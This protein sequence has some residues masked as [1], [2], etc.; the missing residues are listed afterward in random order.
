[1]AQAVK[2]NAMR[3]L[4]KAKIDYSVFTYDSDEFLDGVTVAGMVNKPV[5]TVFK[6]LLTVGAG[7]NVYVFVIPVAATLDMKAAARA[8]SEKSVSMLPVAKITAVSGYIKGG[9]SP[10]GMK[11]QYATVIDESARDLKL[12]TFSA[13]KRGM[14]LETSPEDL[15]KVVGATFTAVIEKD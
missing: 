7:N 8:V 1:M 15:A 11:K 3:I 4:E 6:T 9:C 2:T 12:I 13:G 14:Q 10:I 5:E